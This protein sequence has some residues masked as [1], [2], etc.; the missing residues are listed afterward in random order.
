MVDLCKLCKHQTLH[1]TLQWSTLLSVNTSHCNKTTFP[2]TA[3]ILIICWTA[4]VTECP[5]CIAGGFLGFY[6]II[7]V[8]KFTLFV[9]GH[10]PNTQ[11]VNPTYQPASISVYST[12]GSRVILSLISSL[13]SVPTFAYASSN[14]FWVNRCQIPIPLHTNGIQ[15]NIFELLM[16]Y[17]LAPMLLNWN[18]LFIHYIHPSNYLW[19]FP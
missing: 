19:V 18:L 12:V 10:T 13:T 15:Y 3:T 16:S 11:W 17:P 9:N 14:K 6:F 4:D 2:T 8:V 7:S 5:S 1:C